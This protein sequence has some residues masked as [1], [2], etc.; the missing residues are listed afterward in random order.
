MA[1]CPSDAEETTSDSN[2]G[3]TEDDHRR[4]KPKV[5]TEDEGGTYLVYCIPD[6]HLREAYSD[7]LSDI[8]PSSNFTLCISYS[9]PRRNNIEFRLDTFWIRIKWWKI[10][11]LTIWTT[12][13]PNLSPRGES[14]TS[15][16][17]TSV[18]RTVLERSQWI[19]TYFLLCLWTIQH[20][21]FFSCPIEWRANSL[22]EE[23]LTIPDFVLKMRVIHRFCPFECK[24]EKSHATVLEMV[25]N[26]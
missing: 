14:F 26:D 7:T 11:F 17:T 20:D 10:H 3:T 4:R 25:N 5:T 23:L 6:S 9:H 16:V 8:L 19:S 13:I 18:P 15:N 24:S 1:V 2:R 21:T 12:A 22:R